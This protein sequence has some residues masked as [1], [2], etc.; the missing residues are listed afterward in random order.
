MEGVWTGRIKKMSNEE[1]L[2][3]TETGRIIGLKAAGEILSRILEGRV[4]D[5]DKYLRAILGSIKVEG[6]PKAQRKAKEVKE[7]ASKTMIEK[8]YLDEPNLSTILREIDSQKILERAIR[9]CLA[10]DRNIPNYLLGEMIRRI[11]SLSLKE[12]LAKRILNQNL[13]TDDFLVIEEELEDLKKFPKGSPLQIEALE[14]HWKIGME[15]EN[16][17]WLIGFVPSLAERTWER[18][19]R[20]GRVKDLSMEELDEIFRYTESPEIKMKAG[21]ELLPR[22]EKELK[23]A[24][25]LLKKN[26][27]DAEMFLQVN[28]LEGDVEEL[29]KELKKRLNNREI[30]KM[31][32]Y[33]IPQT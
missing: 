5:E 32:I 7:E 33:T 20:E 8:G 31:K 24:R 14:K 15:P 3:I 19:C 22:I 25:E 28:G 10:K 29:R 12:T 13:T 4:T 6:E 9:K 11:K 23:R 30:E 21:K 1:L 26:P 17:C 2:R 18:L 16:A 27:G